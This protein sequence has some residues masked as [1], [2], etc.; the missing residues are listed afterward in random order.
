M[1]SFNALS[2]LDAWLWWWWCYSALPRNGSVEKFR[3]DPTVE[4]YPNVWTRDPRMEEV[5]PKMLCRRCPYA[6]QSRRRWVTSCGWCPQTL[7]EEYCF[8][9]IL[10][11]L[12]AL[13]CI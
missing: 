9:F 1:L 13:V 11:S 6:G 7:Q 4:S 3:G 8:R 12:D 2:S 5:V 10:H